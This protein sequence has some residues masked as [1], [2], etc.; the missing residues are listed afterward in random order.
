[1]EFRLEVLCQTPKLGTLAFFIPR[2]SR[3]GLEPDIMDGSAW[4]GLVLLTERG[5][6]SSHPL[7]R[8]LVPPI[9]HLGANIRDFSAL[10]RT[11]AQRNCDFWPTAKFHEAERSQPVNLKRRCLVAP[12]QM[13]TDWHTCWQ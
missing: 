9:D 7:G 4:V 6:S 5:V 8:A 3:R 1:M 10:V 12:Q 2:L 13:C 11:G